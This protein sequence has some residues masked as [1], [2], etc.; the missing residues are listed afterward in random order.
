M[1][2]FIALVAGALLSVGAFAAVLT[3]TWTNATQNTDGTAIPATGPGSI[4]NTRVEYGTCNGT[5]FGTKVGEVVV[6]GSATTTP[7]PNLA[8]GTYCGRAIHINTYGEESAPSNVATKTINA[9][10]PRPPSNF[11]L[12]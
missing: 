12:G 10:V 5:A 6:A 9:P 1:R 7:T 8:P 2:K 3:V 11:S 4:A